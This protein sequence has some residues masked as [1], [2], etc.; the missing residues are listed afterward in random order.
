VRVNVAG[1][2]GALGGHLVA[3]LLADGHDVVASDLK[4]TSYWW[5]AHDGA[6]N[7]GGVD[8]ATPD[9]AAL[10][11]AGAEW[12]FDMAE[13]MGGVYFL[14]TERVACAESIEIGINLLRESSRAGVRRFWHCG[15]ACAYPVDLQTDADVVALREDM[16]WPANPE[17]AYGLSKLYMEELCRHYRDDGLIETR[18]GRFHNIYGPCAE[19]TGGREKSPAAVCRKVAEAVLTGQ[20]EIEIWGDGEQTR[21]YC[22]VDDMVEGTLRLMASD[23]AHPVNIGSDRMVTVNQ[24]VSIVESVAG[25]TLERRY[26]PDMP[27]GVRG[28]N[29]DLTLARDVLGWEP[30]VTLE[31]GIARTYAW[32]AQQVASFSS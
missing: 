21:S 15:S 24:L 5:Q 1:A 25:V 19:Y 11:V 16:A 17:P 32:V 14:H 9:G 7:F 22:Y 3:R 30:Q 2:G 28:R 4:S 27:Q 29:A 31:D 18:V 12:V 13:Q 8:C 6:T 23:Y 10:A 26:R 20:H